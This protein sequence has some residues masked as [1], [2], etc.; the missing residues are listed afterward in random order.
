V[1]KTH[2]SRYLR[3]HVLAQLY[4]DSDGERVG[5][6]IYSLSDPR[7]IRAVRYVGRTRAPKRR[8]IQHLNTARLWLPDERPFWVAALELRPLYEWIRELYLDERRL[9]T[10]VVYEWVATQPQARIRERSRIY[11]C[12]QQSL[13]LLNVEAE[14]SRVQLTLI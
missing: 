12:L 8:F 7:D 5:T 11:E 6:A 3:N 2:L 4:D 14:N 1:T 9:P 10:M 13:P